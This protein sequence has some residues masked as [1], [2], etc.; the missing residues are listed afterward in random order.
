MTNPFIDNDTNCSSRRRFCSSLAVISCSLVVTPLKAAT[1]F[2]SCEPDINKIFT[3]NSERVG[4][5][6]AEHLT[7]EQLNQIISENMD[8]ISNLSTM[9]VTEI[10]ELVSKDFTHGR[11]TSICSCIFSNKE[12]TLCL[13]SANYNGIK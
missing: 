5:W 8:L 13:I 6:M 1:N 2:I 4:K 3:K 9:T 7:H 11:V 10:G 12:V